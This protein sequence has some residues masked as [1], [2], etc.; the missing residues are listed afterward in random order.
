IPPLL[1]IIFVNSAAL[2]TLPPIAEANEFGGVLVMSVAEFGVVSLRGDGNGGQYMAIL[3]AGLVVGLALG[4]WRGRVEE[5]TGAPAR[6]RIWGGRTFLVS[7]VVGY[8]A[9]SGRVVLSRPEVSG[10]SMTG[11]SRM[12]LPFVWVLVGLVLYTS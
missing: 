6:R 5:R 10:L 3:V 2:A 7:A 1:A 9:L 8:L 4:A 12:G 11:G